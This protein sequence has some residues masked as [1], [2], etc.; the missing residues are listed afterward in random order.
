MELSKVFSCYVYFDNFFHNLSGR[1]CY[2]DRTLIL[3]TN[4][5]GNLQQ[6]MGGITIR[7]WKFKCSLIYKEKRNYIQP[8]KERLQNIL[9]IR[10]LTPVHNFK[11]DTAAI[12]SMTAFLS[13]KQFSLMKQ[14]TFKYCLLSNL[15]GY[16]RANT[17]AY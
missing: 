1:R 16:P 6:L 11:G 4:I 12:V 3:V 15:A 13:G 10:R 2:L 17:L 9:Q 7:S 8:R 5:Q 14:F